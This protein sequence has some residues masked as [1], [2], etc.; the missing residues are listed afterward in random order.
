[1]STLAVAHPFHAILAAEI[2]HASSM[3]RI[4]FLFSMMGRVAIPA[5]HD[6]LIAAIDHRF[7]FA[8]ATN[9]AREIRIAKEHICSPSSG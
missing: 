1:M 7:D 8:G 5:G 9:Y 6:E 4:F 3:E 2:K